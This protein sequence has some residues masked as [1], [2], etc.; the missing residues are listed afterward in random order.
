MLPLLFK[1]YW[2]PIQLHDIPAIREDDSSAA[3]L[4]AFR[5]DQARRDERYAQKHNGQMRKRDLGLDLLRFF[6]PEITVQAVRPPP[7]AIKLTSRSG[8]PSSS[9]C[10]T[11]PRQVSGCYSNTSA[12]AV[13]PKSNPHTSHSSTSP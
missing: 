3:S 12:S 5:A 13:R 4:G 2:T 11:F 10:N 7:R 1:H 9:A 8:R 6:S